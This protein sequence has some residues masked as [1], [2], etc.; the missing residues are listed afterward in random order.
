MEGGK[1]GGEGGGGRRTSLLLH[2][3]AMTLSGS[4]PYCCGL[5]LRHPGLEPS[6]PKTT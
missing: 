3:T 5:N 4:M 1:G 6:L 2:T